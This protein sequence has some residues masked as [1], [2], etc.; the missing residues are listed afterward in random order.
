MPV[1]DKSIRRAS[2][3]KPGEE[4]E[5]WMSKDLAEDA[6]WKKM[7]QNTFTRWVCVNSIVD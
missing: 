3:A 7:Q 5:D 1:D 6:V 2:K 4:D